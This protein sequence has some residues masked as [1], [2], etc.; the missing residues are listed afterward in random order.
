MSINDEMLNNLKQKYSFLTTFVETGTYKATTSKIAS[1]YFQN[2]FTIEIFQD[3]Y[4]NIEDK[5]LFTNI[6]YI[7]G[8]S[9]KILPELLITEKQNILFFLD[10]HRSGLDTSSNG[11]FIVP[12]MEELNII[13]NNIKGDN[14]LVI[15]DVRFWKNEKINAPD[16]SNVSKHNILK[17]ILDSKKF[18]IQEVYEENDKYIIHITNNQ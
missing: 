15:N 1:K 7:L 6:K 17:T 18:I 13:L 12:V 3:L 16:W 10:A 5:N 11:S 4:D 14:I 8:D 2:I 9:V